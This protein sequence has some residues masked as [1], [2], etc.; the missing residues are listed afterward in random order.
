MTFIKAIKLLMLR[1]KSFKNIFVDEVF[2]VNP[3]FI[4]IYQHF[5]PNAS[6]YGLGDHKQIQTDFLGT[7]PQYKVEFTSE[8]LSYSVRVPKVVEEKIRHYIPEFRANK[9]KEGSLILKK[10]GD[11][12]REAGDIMICATQN[13]KDYLI[14]NKQPLS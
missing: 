1:G 6:I 7:A 9:K 14:K 2:L 11:F 3:Y 5:A 8:Y 12:A 13:M 4:D 10:F